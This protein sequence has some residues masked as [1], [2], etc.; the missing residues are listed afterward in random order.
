MKEQL[1]ALMDDQLDGAECD[2]CLRRLKDDEALRADWELYHL[3]GDAIRGT[4]ARET[5]V[6]GTRGPNRISVD[7]T[8]NAPRN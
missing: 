3:I 6:V 7:L 4:P 8:T 5:L 1:S 2:G